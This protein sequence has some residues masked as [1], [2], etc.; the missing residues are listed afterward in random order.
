MTILARF[1]GV[2]IYVFRILVII[3][4][5]LFG[6]NAAQTWEES[7]VRMIKAVVTT[8]LL[9]ARSATKIDYTIDYDVSTTFNG[10]V[11]KLVLCAGEKSYF[12]GIEPRGFTKPRITIERFL[13]YPILLTVGTK[14]VL[15]FTVDYQA[16][17][18]FSPKIHEIGRVPFTI[19]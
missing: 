2:P 7:P 19:N 5:V 12:A 3:V 4:L 1:L 9:L 17:Y 11:G 13:E 14:C 15:V 8:S 16:W 6:V 10:D 18:S